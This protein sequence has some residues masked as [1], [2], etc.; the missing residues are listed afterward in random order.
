MAHVLTMRGTNGHRAKEVL[1]SSERDREGSTSA[2]SPAAW[3]GSLGAIAAVSAV[4]R[5]FGLNPATV[6][7][8]YLIVVLLASMR[9]GLLLGT[10]CSLLATLSY[11]VFF[12]PPLYRLTIHEPENWVALGAFLVASVVVSRL[13]VAA[14]REA[15]TARRRTAELETLHGLSIDLFAAEDRDAA[16]G[17]ALELL[18]ARQASRPALESAARLFALAI[19][20]ERL[21]EERAH[22]AALRESEALKTSLLR[23]VSHDLTTPIT[24]ITIQ[25][26]ALRRVAGGEAVDAIEAETSRLRRRVENLLAMARLEAGNARPRREPTPPADLFRAVRENLP[27]VFGARPIA[28]RVEDDCPEADVD[29]SLALEVLVNLVE[30]AHRAS[31]PGSPVDLVASRSDTG[32]RLEVLDRG[33]GLPAGLVD[34]A[35]NLLG[36]VAPHGL[37]L[38]IARGLAAANGGLL[39]LLPRAGGG[40]EARLELPAA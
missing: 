8:G 38:E 2:G 23:A 35:G 40:T 29:P 33:P 13:V 34:G 36:D 12:F 17:H 27:L 31:P 28:V 32:V 19:E 4:G 3:L 15:E 6:G 20:R 26:E 24:A 9:G 11:N 10:A 39:A 30:N 22:L 5:L 14:R 1:K 18:D 7:F 16:L 25:I 21:L 37:G